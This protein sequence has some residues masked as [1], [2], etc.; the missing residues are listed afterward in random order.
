MNAFKR[1]LTHVLLLA[2]FALERQSSQQFES[3]WVTRSPDYRIFA[4]SVYIHMSWATDKFCTGTLVAEKWVLTA[5][6]CMFQV[7]KRV[8]S[9]TRE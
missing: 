6:R 1:I 3:K 9:G 8:A 5:S 7:D 4:S 2:H